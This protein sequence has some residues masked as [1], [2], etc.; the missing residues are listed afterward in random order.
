MPKPLTLTALRVLSL[1]E[2][3]VIEDDI[4]RS[5]DEAE[6]EVDS[7]AETRNLLARFLLWAA[8]PVEFTEFE[9]AEPLPVESFETLDS[10]TQDSERTLHSAPA[11]TQTSVES[12]LQNA[13]SETEQEMHVSF[14]SA[15][16]A[17]NELAAKDGASFSP[18]SQRAW[19][20]IQNGVRSGVFFAAAAAALKRGALAQE[21]EHHKAKVQDW[22]PEPS[23]KL[24]LAPRPWTVMRHMG[25]G[26]VECISH[27]PHSMV[28]LPGSEIQAPVIVSGCRSEMMGALKRVQ[29]VDQRELQRQ[30]LAE[31]V[32]SFSCVVSDCAGCTPIN[33]AQSAEF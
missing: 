3:A 19:T 9:N 33:M 24:E 23:S 29:K 11:L 6:K 17:E 1:N 4:Q 2:I 7:E 13:V 30:T 25:S 31:Q 21:L 10:T 12:C 20:A 5:L 22:L 15:G 27:E 26:S 8:V 18:N 16:E 32:K 14:E 28:L